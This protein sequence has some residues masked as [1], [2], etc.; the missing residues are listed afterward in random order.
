VY[1][2]NLN[3]ATYMVGG[4]ERAGSF[5]TSTC[6]LCNSNPMMRMGVFYH[7]PGGDGP[8]LTRIGV[9]AAD[10][11]DGSTWWVIRFAP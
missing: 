3:T 4:K 10:L 11:G 1:I 6:T 7:D 2:A 8:V 5:P 9:G